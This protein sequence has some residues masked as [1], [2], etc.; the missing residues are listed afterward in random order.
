MNMFQEIKDAVSVREA[1][2]FYDLKINR[3][4]MCCCP[5]HDDRH[6]SM[7]LD[8]R[9]HCFG[10]QADGDVIDLVQKMFG[11]S[12]LD[13][14][15]KLID[16][17][18]LNINTEKHE[19]ALDRNIRIQ[20]AREK[21]HELSVRRAYAEEL[22]QF[23][24]RM[25]CFFHIIQDWKKSYCPTRTQWEED[26]IDERYII[27]I[28]SIGAVENILDILDFGENDEIYELF[29]HRGEII[30]TYERKITKAEQGTATGSG[31]GTA[32]DGKP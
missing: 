20:R 31:N 16:D 28:N 22:R 5:F 21:E 23:Q 25:I 32:S 24:L 19:S 4:K 3:N 26:M 9:F 18:R 27:A 12:T 2:S 29:K 10:C 15:R 1:A 13:A 30:D 8:S 11:L 7:K 6:P 17:F 14:A